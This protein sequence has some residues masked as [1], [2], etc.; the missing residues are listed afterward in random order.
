MTPD[1]SPPNRPPGS[2]EPL[3]PG[4]QAA[5]TGV[6]PGTALALLAAVLVTAPACL[7]AVYLAPQ[8]LR[9]EVAWGSGAAA[10]AL[11]AAVATAAYHLLTA[12]RLRQTVA[13]H[14]AAAVAAEA[15]ALQFAEV[16]VPALVERLRDGASADTALA[17][18]STGDDAARKRVLST[19]ATEV[20]RSETMRAAAMSACANAAGR[21]QALTTS[22]AAD[23][24]EMEHKHS[25]EDVLGDLL[26]LDHRT[27][28]AGR[29]ADCI[30]V[31][32]GARS[33]RR[34]AKPI[35]MESILRGAM[36]RISGYQR[37]RLH[38]TS[39]AA[40]AGHA[41]EG[42]MHALAELMDNAANFSPP[43]AEVH[44]Y[45]EEVSAGVVIMVEDGGLVMGEVAL[46]RAEEAVSPVNWELAARSGT[47]LGLPVVGRLAKKHG[48]SV[49]FRP[50]AHGG[51]GVL[52]MIPQE[53]I[54]RAGG[55]EAGTRPRARAGSG[56]SGTSGTSSASGTDTGA[57]STRT[58]SDAPPRTEPAE[59]EPA[60]T[61]PATRT[62]I[63]ATPD[64]AYASVPPEDDAAPPLDTDTMPVRVT[65]A[66]RAAANAQ[67]IR[68]AR[69]AADAEIDA[70]ADEAVEIPVGNRTAGEPPPEHGNAADS[71][72]DHGTVQYGES[73]LP[74]RP[75]GR[76]LAAARRPTDPA[77]ATASSEAR[78]T[79]GREAREARETRSS[80]TPEESGSRFGAFRR[81]VREGAQPAD[82]GSAAAGTP[83]TSPAPP[84]HS[85]SRPE[86][87]AE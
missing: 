27:A 50:S 12:R 16:T 73:G 83:R 18:V 3:D 31:L 24:R 1:I 26:H 60:D 2:S 52:L 66:L 65:A 32:T 87:E 22:M 33:G 70:H 9:P 53:L 4:K 84:A 54:T 47:R 69:K 74:K 57:L 42:V 63:P 68:D 82:D 29:L 34:W 44:V 36:G 72:E 67:N 48:L 56:T 13:D 7:L 80:R 64:A 14:Q 62:V 21:V 15:D 77:A 37:I 5:G 23:L 78:E 71:T 76:T 6:G 20:H 85:S 8:S 86:D 25:D 39:T 11:W 51:T 38:S 35:V 79:R 81:A 40:V 49:S 19:L 59:P 46:R 61:A 17:S 30:A 75:R 41:A 10:V 55:R 58:P 28:Q 43:T 45:V